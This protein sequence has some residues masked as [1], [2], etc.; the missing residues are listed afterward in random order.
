MGE[1]DDVGELGPKIDQPQHD[2]ALDALRTE[3]IDTWNQGDPG[4]EHPEP[5]TP[6]TI[7]DIDID[8]SS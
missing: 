1:N 8:G 6:V 7:E 3:R 4:D 2:A 5:G